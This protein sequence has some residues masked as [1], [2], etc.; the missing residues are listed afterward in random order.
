MGNTSKSKT[1]MHT[2]VNSWYWDNNDPKGRA[3]KPIPSKYVYTCRMNRTAS[4]NPMYRDLIKQGL[5]ATNTLILTS[6]EVFYEKPS[7][8]ATWV[9]RTNTPGRF[10]SQITTHLLNGLAIGTHN[11]LPP[12]LFTSDVRNKALIGII[13]KVRKYETSDLSGPTFAGELRETV[14][15][16]R[17]PFKALRQKTGLFTDL[18]MRILRD[19]Q[20][21]G[22]KKE[23]A[24]SKV[25]SDTYLEWTFGAAP[26]ISDISA[27]MD[28]YLNEKARGFDGLKR[29]SYRFTDDYHVEQGRV[30]GS[31]YSVGGFFPYNVFLHHR[32]SCQYVVWID[33]SLLFADSQADWLRNAAKFNLDEIVP[34]AWEL[35]PW[36]FLIDYFTNIGD[37]LGCT[38]NYNRNVAFGKR[39]DHDQS[40]MFHVPLGALS[41]SPSVYVLDEFKP[42][43]YT[44]TNKRIQRTKVSKLG[45]PQ[46]DVSLPSVGQAGNILALVRSLALNNPFKGFILK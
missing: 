6:K 15:M 39:T 35:L 14:K 3:V 23:E 33:E 34:T 8:R 19:K 41:D 45:F 42:W 12:T 1:I 20:K 4:D 32:S 27:I 10:G 28:V 9:S 38:F 18:H 40:V 22:R 26:L 29:L 21:A 43:S 5:D 11:T 13:K 46:L 24:W 17:S 25:I 30:N 37:V 44:S 31:W 7:C 16:I 2:G 36:S